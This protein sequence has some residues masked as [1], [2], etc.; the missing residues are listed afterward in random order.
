[1]KLD[2][3]NTQATLQ[4]EMKRLDRVTERLVRMMERVAHQR[5]AVTAAAEALANAIGSENSEAPPPPLEE[6]GFEITASIREILRGSENSMSAPEIRDAL[7]QRGWRAE[8]YDNPLAVVHTILKRLLKSGDAEDEEYMDGG[9]GYFD[10]RRKAEREAEWQARH[11]ESA[12]AEQRQ[13][14][15]VRAVRAQVRRELMEASCAVVRLCPEGVSAREIQRELQKTAIVDLSSWVR[16]TSAIA[17][18]LK[19]AP[20]IRMF[21]VERN[22]VV[23]NIYRWVRTQAGSEQRQAEKAAK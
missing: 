8:D 16:P 4:E 12:A 9:R 21:R 18:V 13:E 1:M 20:G 3:K 11:E 6:A 17:M 22:G 5:K 15:A 23:A 2:Y 14:A 10:P 7:A 19:E